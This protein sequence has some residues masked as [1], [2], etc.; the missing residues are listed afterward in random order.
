[1]ML[2]FISVLH[3]LASAGKESCQPVSRHTHEY[4][5]LGTNDTGFY[6]VLRPLHRHAM[7]HVNESCYTDE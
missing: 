3:L 1:M 5:T 4:I 2:G 6:S 7:S